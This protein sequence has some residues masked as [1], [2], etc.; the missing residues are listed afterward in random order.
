MQLTKISFQKEKGISGAVHMASLIPMG[1][2]D[3]CSD[4]GMTDV[5]TCPQSSL[6]IG[7][8]VGINIHSKIQAVS[9]GGT[10]QIRHQIVMVRTAAVL[11]T[12]GHLV[13]PALQS[14]PHT[15]HVHSEDL[16]HALRN[17][18]GA[19]VSYLLIYGKMLVDL[20]FQLDLLILDIFGVAHQDGCA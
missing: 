9:P 16:G 15:A 18:S 19:A 6:G 13:F 4:E 8:I 2:I 14:V 1:S 11:G 17:G 5:I 12:D 20:S 3:P 7:T 10:D